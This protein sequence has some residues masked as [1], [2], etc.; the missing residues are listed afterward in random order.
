MGR[1][2]ASPCLLGC[3]GEEAGLKGR[4][5]KRGLNH[6]TPLKLTVLSGREVCGMRGVAVK[7]IDI[8][9]NS[10]CESGVPAP[11]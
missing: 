7:Y 4:G 3:K 11:N 1:V 9:Q 6:R 10:E 5:K 2:D 8:T